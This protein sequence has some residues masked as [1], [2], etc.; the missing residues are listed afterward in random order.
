MK[1]KLTAMR[2]GSRNHLRK[3]GGIAC[4][5]YA[6]LVFCASPSSFAQT[7]DTR[8]VVATLLLSDA[9]TM[10]KGNAQGNQDLV[11]AASGAKNFDESK[12][13]LYFNASALPSDISDESIQ[14]QLTLKTG[15]DRGMAITVVAAKA[16]PNPSQ[17]QSYTPSA[18]GVRAT[19]VSPS[20]NDPKRRDTT[21][22]VTLKPGSLVPGTSRYIGLLL[23]A[24]PN[25]SRRVYYGLGSKDDPEHLPRLIVTYKRKIPS[26]PACASV[27][28]T[29]AAIQSDGRSG[30]T[31]ACSFV[32]KTGTA[33]NDLGL[34]PYPVAAETSTTAPVTYRDRL[35]VV[36]AG[37]LEELNAL[38]AL[39]GSLA[40]GGEVR[41]RSTMVIDD[42]GRLRILTNDAIYTAQLASN[43]PGKS[44]LP[45][46]IDKKPYKFD[47]APATVVPGPDGTLYIVKQGIFALNPEVGEQN[48]EGK[49]VQPRKL[50]QVST[51]ND[52]NT[53][54]TLSPSGR[55]L[56]VL[57]GFAGNKS[58]FVAIDAQSGKSIQLVPGKL[59]ASGQ[60]STDFPDDL[61]SFRS[62]VVAEG[63]H[64]VDFVYIAG[65][66]GSSGVLWAVENDPVKQGGEVSARFTRVWKYPLDSKRA[67]GQPI[68]SP[69]G[70]SATGDLA[71]RRFYF[72]ER[73]LPGGARLPGL[74]A[75]SALDVKKLTET[76]QPTGAA[77]QWNT[78]VNPVVDS[79]G[80]IMFWADKTLY[81]FYPET[82]SLTKHAVEAPP[83]QL[84]FGPSGILYAAY[85]AAKSE[86]TVSALIPSFQLKDAGPMKIYSPST[87][88]V[89]VDPNRKTAK[90]WDLGARESVVL[91][92]D[93]SVKVGETL[94]IR[95]NANQ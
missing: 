77:G 14:L 22:S 20:L 70:R 74:I 69:I 18:D 35:Y 64:G 24:Q 52:Q 93:F 28:S 83:P 43:A 76:P 31:S 13:W 78:N 66:S 46:A 95:V 7:G 4:V 11:V 55:F 8:T 47:Q 49:V 2:M 68:L 56:Y 23:L 85:E 3:A 36:R 54:I 33:S 21:D 37:R 42:F 86:T 41:A 67:T 75:V 12:S 63:L 89:S 25:A 38:G 90:N 94:A 16:G 34:Y 92:G 73:P 5:L 44:D 80:N 87:L 60:S 26:I 79:A 27:P 71:K 9:Q 58:R 84:F 91:G 81:S 59:D 48:G 19:L 50:W 57:A 45:T 62:P 29:L 88:Y 39:I 10:T 72:I 51:S 6:A 40:V 1:Q 30:D 65:S 53:R 61:N 32:F 15:E 82:N 17:P